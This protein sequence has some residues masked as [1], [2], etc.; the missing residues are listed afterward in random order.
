[1]C[2]EFNNEEIKDISEGHVTEPDAETISSDNDNL[3]EADEAVTDVADEVT[4]GS[5]DAS[6]PEE[7]ATEEQKDE[8]REVPENDGGEEQ[9]PSDAEFSEERELSSLRRNRYT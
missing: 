1:M 6:E 3:P 9:A 8:T 5:Q 2:P 4:E 7:Q